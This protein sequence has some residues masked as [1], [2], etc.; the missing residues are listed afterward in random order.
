LVSKHRKY[1][2]SGSRQSRPVGHTTER[3]NKEERQL[4]RLHI[5]QQCVCILW[6]LLR[7]R[8]WPI[9]RTFL[10]HGGICFSVT[11]STHLTWSAKPSRERTFWQ[12]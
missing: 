9:W 7:T 1:Q 10:V 2:S 11:L 3:H 8:K 5:Q 4:R 6:C 12:V